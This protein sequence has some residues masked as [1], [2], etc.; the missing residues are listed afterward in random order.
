MFD[1]GLIAKEQ[2]IFDHLIGAQPAKRNSSVRA[3]RLMLR[4]LRARP[5]L[6]Y[7]SVGVVAVKPG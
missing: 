6:K 5:E 4:T 7:D 1:D 3:W 2:C